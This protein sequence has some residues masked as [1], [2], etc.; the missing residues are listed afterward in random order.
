MGLT[1]QVDMTLSLRKK[2]TIGFGLSVAL[3]ISVVGV[4][5]STTVGLQ[6]TAGL[7]ARAN[8]IVEF[9]TDLHGHLGTA[10]AATMAYLADGDPGHL[11]ERTCRIDATWQALDSLRTVLADRPDKLQYL[12]AISLLI[13]RKI[14][15]QNQR[16]DE[17]TEAHSTELLKWGAEIEKVYGQIHYRIDFE[18]VA[19][20]RARLG[21]AVEQARLSAARAFVVNGMGGALGVAISLA[22]AVIAFREI[23][24]REAAQ[25]S[26]QCAKDAAEVASRFKSEFIANMSHEIRTPMT[27]ILGYADIIL[28]EHVQNST[29]RESVATIKRNGEHLLTI[30]NDILDLS[31]IEMGKLVI[32]QVPWSPRQLIEEVVALLHVRA[33]EKNLQVTVEF[34]PEIPQAI[35]T[36]PTR[37]RQILLNLMGNAIKFT[38][39]GGVHVRVGWEADRGTGPMLQVEIDDTGIGMTPAQMSSLFQAFQQADGSTSRRF[40]GTGL[41][42]AISG[43]LAQMMGGTI[44]VTSEL[45]VGSTFCVSVGGQ[46]AHLRDNDGTASGQTFGAATCDIA[47]APMRRPLEDVRVLL[48]EDSPDNQRLCAVLL[49]KAGAVVTIADNGEV[50]CNLALDALRRAEP[51]HVVLMDMQ[52]PVRDGYE[53]TGELRRQGYTLPIIAFTAHS[54]PADQQKCR[55]AGCDDYLTKPIDRKR[56]VDLVGRWHAEV[57]SN[58]VGIKS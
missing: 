44:T 53:A 1:L 56:L 54:M 41:G 28:D 39:R 58:G 37:L 57:K 19:E 9:A 48:A 52:M 14:A 25:A 5:F 17:R 30:I 42:L 16:I 32:E 26:L 23:R 49:G 43:R 47:S 51:F 34:G 15:E 31:K 24:S 13:R 27:A 55:D 11:E 21:G 35:V 8:R 38:E 4:S 7:A 29:V 3:L 40:G 36:D 12:D 10:D 22:A 45:G 20:E 50:A 46:P 6:T 2:I 18:I 33:L